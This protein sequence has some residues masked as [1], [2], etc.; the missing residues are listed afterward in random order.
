MTEDSPVTELF[1]SLGPTLGASF[2]FSF[3]PHGGSADEN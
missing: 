1:L 2:T 3:S